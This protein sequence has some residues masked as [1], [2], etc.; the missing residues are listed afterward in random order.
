MKG[1]GVLAIWRSLYCTNRALSCGSVD[2]MLKACSIDESAMQVLLHLVGVKIP[3]Q[4]VCRADC[5]DLSWGRN[6]SPI[7]L[8]TSKALKHTTHLINSRQLSAYKCNFT[9]PF[10]R[11]DTFA[12][13]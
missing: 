7:A 13:P 3:V 1:G 9:T 10:M 4:V 12:Q 5:G 6:R 11:R 8:P 2:K